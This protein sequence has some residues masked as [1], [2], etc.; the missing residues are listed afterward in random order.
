MI[1]VSQDW[2]DIQDLQL[3]PESNVYIRKTGFE[4]SKTDL[5]SFRYNQHGQVDNSVIPVKEINFEIFNDNGDFV[6]GDLVNV[7]FA[8]LINGA[9]EEINIGEFLISKVEKK[10]NGITTRFTL[11]SYYTKVDNKVIPLDEVYLLGSNTE[12]NQ[13]EMDLY[14]L[15]RK[16]N[17]NLDLSVNGKANIGLAEISYGEALQ[18]VAIMGSKTLLPIHSTSPYSVVDVFDILYGSDYLVKEFIQYAKPEITKDN[19]YSSIKMTIN[20]ISSNFGIYTSLNDFPVVD[21]GEMTLQARTSYEVKYKGDIYRDIIT[22][23]TQGNW[24]CQ[25]NTLFIENT[26]YFSKTIHLYM[27][28]IT[29]RNDLAPRTFTASTNLQGDAELEI[30]N[31]YICHPHDTKNAQFQNIV[32]YI[33][34]CHKYTDIIDINC[35][36]DP[37]IELFDKIYIRFEN[38]RYNVLA[39]DITIT[40]DGG[41]NGSIKGRIVATQQ[42]LATPIISFATAHIIHFSAIPNA[43]GYYLFVNGEKVATFSQTTF[44]LRTIITQPSVNTIQVQAFATGYLDSDLSNELTYI[45]HSNSPVLIEKTINAYNDFKFVIQNLSTDTQTLVLAWSREFDYID[46]EPNETF[47]IEYGDYQEVDN[48]VYEYTNQPSTL[49]EDLYCFFEDEGDNT[50]ILEAN[51]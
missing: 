10:A 15:S 32:N 48:A 13:S 50:I 9:Y 27:N 17:N 40:Y 7:Y 35:R 25:D 36:I 28:R 14:V 39:E 24:Y 21:K 16:L 22:D 1:N 2:K 20:Y 8:F 19:V 26:T 43:D 51:E 18:N 46:L 37:R 47:T 4:L 12:Y 31:K 49:E 45:V 44:D 38:T 3:R 42:Q 5:Q 30:M 23:H 34:N 41:F 33:A 6:N 29:P 11:T